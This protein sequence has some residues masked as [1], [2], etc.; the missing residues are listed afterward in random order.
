MH[1]AESTL[2]C[3][4]PCPKCGS[5]RVHRTHRRGLAERLLCLAG[6]RVKT[7]HQ[8]GLRF[9]RYHGLS[10]PMADTLRFFRR[11]SFLMVAIIGVV[12]V[13]VAIAWYGK[14]SA[15]EVGQ[16]SKPVDMRMEGPRRSELS[17]LR[18]LTWSARATSCRRG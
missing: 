17:G 6:A 8:C 15:E 1:P 4:H 14:R 13:L 16:V 11:L 18:P 9:L 2:P 5:I 10:L 3:T 12:L 7:C